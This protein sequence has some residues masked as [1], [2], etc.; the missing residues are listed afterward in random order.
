MRVIK[1]FSSAHFAPFLWSFPSGLLFVALKNP[2]PVHYNEKKKKNV[3]LY[4]NYYTEIKIFHFFQTLM[5]ISFSKLVE[6]ASDQTERRERQ[7]SRVCPKTENLTIKPCKMFGRVI[8]ENSGYFKKSRQKLSIC[9]S[10]K[11]T[12]D[13]F[14]S[15]EC[16]LSFSTSRKLGLCKIPLECT[17]NNVNTMSWVQF[18]E[19]S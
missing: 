13:L 19:K 16:L 10:L 5:Q 3:I 2:S 6:N 18:L 14:P 4:Y 9:S 7:F 17:S 11:I 1:F 12:T 15:Y 8:N